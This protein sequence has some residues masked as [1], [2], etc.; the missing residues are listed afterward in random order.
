MLPKWKFNSIVCRQLHMSW[1][2]LHV[3]VRLFRGILPKHGRKLLQDCAVWRVMQR[4]ELCLRWLCYYFNQ[5]LGKTYEMFKYNSVKIL[6]YFILFEKIFD[7][8]GLFFTLYCIFIFWSCVERKCSCLLGE[9]QYYDPLQAR[10]ISYAGSQC[11]FHYTKP[12]SENSYCGEIAE[13]INGASFVVGHRC[14][15]KVGYSYT[16]NRK[17]LAR[18][19]TQ[20]S[21]ENSCNYDDHLSCLNGICNLIFYLK[22]RS[23]FFWGYSVYFDL[24]YIFYIIRSMQ[25]HFDP[26][27]WRNYWPM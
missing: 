2:Q 1:L 27:Y 21:T 8:E 24:L 6:T 5:V 22:E 7:K 13:N 17:C 14:L 15:C 9:N 23:Q 11:L 12:C 18:F 26:S 20:C 25:R 4:R 10:C 3:L 19:S 16:R